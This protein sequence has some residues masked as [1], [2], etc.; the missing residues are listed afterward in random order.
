MKNESD[1]ITDFMPKAG[2]PRVMAGFLLLVL[3]SWVIMGLAAARVSFDSG[4]LSDIFWT[5][6]LVVF[7]I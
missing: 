2:W 6:I 7:W 5:E 3:G 1:R 4:V